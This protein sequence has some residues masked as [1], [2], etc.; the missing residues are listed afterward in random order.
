MSPALRRFL[1]RVVPARWIDWYRRR[2][3]LRRYLRGLGQELLIRRRLELGI[4]PGPTAAHLAERP[5]QH[6]VE[7]AQLALEQLHRQLEGLN[8]RH[9]AE[10]RRLRAEVAELASAVDALRAELAALNGPA[11]AGGGPPEGAPAGERAPAA[12]RASDG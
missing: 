6:A 9:G 8:A 7:R 2:G 3:L 1:R 11:G 5:L 4:D 10:L 12:E